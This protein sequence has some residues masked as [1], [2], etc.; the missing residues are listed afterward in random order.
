MPIPF[1]IVRDR[2]TLREIMLTETDQPGQGAFALVLDDETFPHFRHPQSREFALALE[3]AASGGLGGTVKLGD[4]EVQVEKSPGG[5]SIRTPA[6]D[7]RRFNVD[8][9]CGLAR[10]LTSPLARTL[11]PAP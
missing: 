6:G 9:A 1:K 3:S 10:D 8:D 4:S 2:W 5:V 11:T 7:D